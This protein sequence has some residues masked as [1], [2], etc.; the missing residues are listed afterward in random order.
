MRDKDSFLMQRCANEEPA[1]TDVRWQFVSRRYEPFR[2]IGATLAGLAA[3][4]A[5][6]GGLSGYWTVYKAVTNDW[7]GQQQ[8]TSEVP[9]LSI[10]VL[11]FENLTGDPAQDFFGDAIVDNLTTDLSARIPVAVVIASESSLGF[12]NKP[13]DPQRVGKQLNV[14]Y[15][16]M[17]SVLRIGT[18]VRINARLIDSKDSQQLWADRFEGKMADLPS[19]QDQMTSRISNSLQ[20]TLPAVSVRRTQKPDNQDAFETMLRGQVALNDERRRGINPR[21][22][23]ES[24]FRRAL[25]LEPDNPGILTS[26]GLVVAENLFNSRL[27]PPA[28]QPPLDQASARRREGSELIEKATRLLPATS[29]TRLARALLSLYDHNFEDARLQLEQARSMN[30][31]D[32]TILY[33]LCLDYEYVGRPDKALPIF[34]EIYLRTAG[35]VPAYHIILLNWGRSLLLLGRWSDALAKLKEVHALRPSPATTGALGI[36]YVQSGDLE[37]ARLHFASWRD[38]HVRHFGVPTIKSLLAFYRESSDVP[39]YLTLVDATMLDGYRKLG[40]SEE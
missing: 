29:D 16:L 36:A 21:R 31:S 14:R 19:L 30:P 1:K 9:R 27:L 28:E 10:A 25:L 18:E 8:V 37:T 33:F 3:M 39:A 34:S 40:I 11:P 5:V 32:Y 26:L 24:Y 2:R 4:G 23:A 7:I 17:G 12:R 20:F 6:L 13:I 38:W 15:L 22:Q 35:R